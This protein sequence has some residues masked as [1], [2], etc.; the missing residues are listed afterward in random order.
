MRFYTKQHKF[1]CG[2]DLHAKKMYLCILDE[3][4]KIKL[5][6]NIKTERE[7]FLKVIEPYREDIVV[8]AECMFTWYQASLKLRPDRLDRRSV[9]RT[10]H[11]LCPWSRTIHE[12]HSR[13]QSQK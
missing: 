3:T 12:S 9:C 8:S 1:Y 6:R 5:H 13:R 7:V 2:I 10:R 11:S 4:G